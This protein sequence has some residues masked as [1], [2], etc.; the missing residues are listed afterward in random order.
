M[1]YLTEIFEIIIQPDLFTRKNGGCPS[2]RTVVSGRWGAL[3]LRTGMFDY[4]QFQ[5]I[6]SYQRGGSTLPGLSV[7]AIKLKRTFPPEPTFFSANASSSSPPVARAFLEPVLLVLVYC[8]AMYALPLAWP[9]RPIPG[10]GTSYPGGGDNLRLENFGK[11]LQEFWVHVFT[12]F[13]EFSAYFE[14][15]FWSFCAKKKTQISLLRDDPNLI[16]AIKYIF[17]V[18][19]VSLVIG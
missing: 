3:V 11:N 17:L 10:H 7:P 8:T 5:G 14:F 13:G 9:C 19:Y 18:L 6:C 15:N 12:I 4:V 16:T 1:C 2:I